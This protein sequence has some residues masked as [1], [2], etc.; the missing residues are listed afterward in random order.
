[1][2]LTFC[3]AA[4]IVTGSCYLLESG[5]TKALVDCGM[6]QGTKEITRHNY[7][8][9]RF[10]PPA[11]SH[12]FL[13]H[14]HIDHS[15]LIPKLVA[16]GFRGKILATSATI[17]LCRIMLQDS[18]EV[19]KVESEEENK[20]REHDG[21]RPR[22]PLYT[23]QEVAVAM[24]LFEKVEYGRLYSMGPNL[25]VR[26]VDA[27]HIIGSSSI[28]VYYT[29][30][31][32]TKKVVFSGDIGQW[33]V[34]IIHDPT[35]IDEADYVVMESTY[36]DRLHEDLQRRDDQLLEVVKEAYRKRGK[37]LIPSFAVERT[38][39]LLYAFHKLFHANRMPDEKVF[40]DSPLAI[41]ATDVF[42]EHREFYDR[43]A[44]KFEDPFS[45]PNLVYTSSVEESK[46]LNT[47]DR[48]CVI[49]AG[50]GMATGGRIRHHFRHGLADPRNTVLFVGYQAEGTTGREILEGAKKVRMMGLSIDV[51]ADIKRIDSFS[52][53]ADYEELLKWINGF[54]KKP[55]KVFLCHG[56]EGSAEA[57]AK[58]LKKQNFKAHIPNIGESAEI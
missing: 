31:R 40:L 33:D 58:K 27:G 38:Q 26:F 52:A 43:E 5:N 54:K 11:I 55:E 8:P 17:D 45:F 12:V 47:Y 23:T 2:K 44:Y 20:R 30:G 13:T 34:P 29:E 4:K 28:E 53:H 3:G 48:P 25:Q 57:F 14:A 41:K 1:M 56:E 15:G 35:L 16:E 6:F 7:E 22:Q 39:E 19:Q 50:N 51:R 42:A 21:L 18:A 36:G 10:D 37:L 46:Q 9:F 24:P 49:I 32:E